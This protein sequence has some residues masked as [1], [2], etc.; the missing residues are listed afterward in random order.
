MDCFTYSELKLE[1]WSDQLLKPLHGKR[2]PLGGMFE[3]TERCNLNCVHCYINQPANNR[4]AKTRELA[5]NQ[6][7]RLLDQVVNSGCLFLVLTG[8]EVFLRPDFPEIYSYAR[9]R[10]MIVTLFTNGTLITPR[11]ADLL[12]EMHP[13]VVEIT[14]YGASKQTYER[15]TQVPGSYGRFRRGV[16]LLLERDIRLSL[17]SVLLTVNRH[18]LQE[19]KTFAEQLGVQFR[20]DGLLWPRL[21]GD[22]TP[23]EYR[24]S[25]QELID[26]DRDDPERQHQWEKQSR[27]FE[28]QLVR[29]EN[30]YSCGAGLRSFHIDSNGRMSICAMAR[31]PSFDLLQMSFQ[32]GWELLGKLRQ[33][34]RQLDTPC[35]TC[36]AGALCNQCP[37]WSQVVHGDDET[38]VEYVCELGK[39][40]SEQALQ[41]YL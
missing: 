26:L 32:Q 37:G 15:V 10:G 17:K 21:D 2:Y 9:Q 34:K 3:L 11:I 23:F 36:T 24:L 29:N 28:G 20:Y 5:T 8:G 31:C 7:K 39:M 33:K 19:M 27:L 35:R 16:E 41:T 18:E 13:H 38:P 4:S 30:V 12:A 1:D 14:L 6:I 22:P 40:R 25:T